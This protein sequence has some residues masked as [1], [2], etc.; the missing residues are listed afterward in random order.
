M[1]FIMH[2]VK[3]YIDM[4][5]D[6]R[7][8]TKKYSKGMILLFSISGSLFA[9]TVAGTCVRLY[10]YYTSIAVYY[11]RQNMTPRCSFSYNGETL[12]ELIQIPWHFY[13]PTL[14]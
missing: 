6:R 12:V 13:N 3:C 8:I 7:E 9:G 11:L 5:S 14:L 10:I 2:H 1:K 4:E